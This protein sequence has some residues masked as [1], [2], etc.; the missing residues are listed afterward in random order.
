MS[1]TFT[2]VC[3]L[4]ESFYNT[5]EFPDGERFNAVKK[6]EGQVCTT[7]SGK[8]VYGSTGFLITLRIQNQSMESKVTIHPLIGLSDIERIQFARVLPTFIRA[9]PPNTE[10][11]RDNTSLDFT[12]SIDH[13]EYETDGILA[14]RIGNLLAIAHTCTH[15]LMEY[16]RKNLPMPSPAMLKQRYLK[17]F[18]VFCKECLIKEPPKQQ[19]QNSDIKTGSGGMSNQEFEEFFKQWK[20]DAEKRHQDT[21]SNKDASYQRSYAWLRG[22]K[23]STREK[24]ILTTFKDNI[25]R[26]V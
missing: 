10:V 1:K 19:T 6:N 20:K 5:F 17:A 3:T 12:E 16:L 11:S 24:E 7:Y 22:T 4:V 25:K 13:N 23:F 21:N 18:S 9:G 26:K 2:E 14:I 8:I 15:A